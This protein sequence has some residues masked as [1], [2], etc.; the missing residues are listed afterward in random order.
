MDYATIQAFQKVT[1][2]KKSP[3][4]QLKALPQQNANSREAILAAALKTFA[5]GGFDG[6]SLPKIAKFA[7][8]H[9]R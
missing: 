8:W 7:R 9:R 3:A 6:A 4:K 5:W 1:L 2:L